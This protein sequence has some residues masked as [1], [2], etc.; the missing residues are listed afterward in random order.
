MNTESTHVIAYIDM[1]GATSRIKSGSENALLQLKQIYEQMIGVYS[2]GAMHEEHIKTKVFSDNI[3]IARETSADAKTISINL[4]QMI[5][6]AAAFQF[7]AIV[8]GWPV[9]GGI[10][11]GNLY[12]DDIF[13]WGTGLV[14]AYELESKIAVT[15]RIVIDPNLESVI[16]DKFT[17]HC[18]RKDA[19]LPIVN[20][21]SMCSNEET[22]EI[23]KNPI[24]ALLKSANETTIGKIEWLKSDFNRVCLEK[25]F[26]DLIIAD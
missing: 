20:Y 16:L 17:V 10:T 26:D 6:L 4:N 8:S 19:G 5:S 15:P 24:I 25:Q 22:M 9:R 11:V 18:W 23:A 21:L 2:A 1:L 7:R 13:V 3:I 12:M 14:R